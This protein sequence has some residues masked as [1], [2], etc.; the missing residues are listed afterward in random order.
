MLYIIYQ[1]I[2]NQLSILKIC[3]KVKWLKRKFSLLVINKIQNQIKEVNESLV[4][5]NSEITI[6]DYVKKI[7]D[8]FYNI[9]ISF[10]DDFIEFVDKEDFIIHHYLLEKYGVITIK[11]TF[12]VKRLLEKYEFEEDKY[13]I[14]KPPNQGEVLITS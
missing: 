8:M 1:D 4:R 14:T 7:N 13:F 5:E 2:E 9:D 12:Y 11:D 6:L 10:I 3:R